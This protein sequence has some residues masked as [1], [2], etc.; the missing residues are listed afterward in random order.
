MSA[1]SGDVLFPEHELY[2][3]LISFL[4]ASPCQEASAVLLREAEQHGLLGQRV[5]VAGGSM[6]A[7][8]SDRLRNAPAPEPAHLRQLLNTLLRLSYQQAPESTR[9]SLPPWTLLR[10][11]PLG[12]APPA[13]Q[14][15][16]PS[17]V[18]GSGSGGGCSS[19]AGGITLSTGLVGF[20]PPPTSAQWRADFQKRLPAQRELTCRR[21]IAGAAA[22]P[23][24]GLGSQVAALAARELGARIPAQLRPPRALYAAPTDSAPFG[25]HAATGRG[26]GMRLLRAICGHGSSVYCCTFDRTGALLVSGSDDCNVK[27]RHAAT[28]EQS[29]VSSEW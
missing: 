10:G 2:M 7:S 24:H 13:G 14:G 21:R 23:T 28:S 8:Y 27:V 26:A 11:G 15:A 9:L 22:A 29:V 16:G 17:D 5:T 20:E 1:P 4:S 6:P 19:K 3:L 18:S 12:L 25:K